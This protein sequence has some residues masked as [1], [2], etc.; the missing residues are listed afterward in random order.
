MR[1]DLILF[2]GNFYTMDE[3]CP[4]AKAVA[5]SGNRFIA[6]GDDEDM[7]GLLRPGGEA[8]NLDGRTVL[9]GF[10]DCHIHFAEYA[11]RMERIDLA[12]VKS[13]E[14]ALELVKERAL[15]SKPGE[16]LLGGGWDRNIWEES[17]FPTKEELDAVS[18]NNPVALHSKDGHVYWVNSS[19][20]NLA[21]IIPS[22]PNPPG[23]EIE[24]DE[25]G[26]PTGILKEK[27][28]ELID[29]VIEEPS[30]ETLQAAMKK[31]IEKAHRVGL[32]GIHD[33]ER[34]HAFIA[35]QELARRGELTLR[36]LMHIPVEE[37]EAAIELGI[38]S[39][40]GNELLR[41]GGVK[42][43]ADGT[44]GSR[45]AAMLAPYEDEP[46]NYG[47]LVTPKEELR[48]IVHK[49]S[50]AGISA[51][52]HAIGDRANRNALDALAELYPSSLRHRIEHAQLLNPLEIPRFARLNVIASVQPIHCTSDM[53]M[54]ERHWGERG[55]WAY[56]FR[57]LLDEGTV[58]AFG[59]DC[60]VEVLDPLIGIHAAVTRR[61]PDGYPGDYGW[62]PEQRISVE[63]AVRAYTLGAAYSSCEESM[64]GS[65]TPG[66]LADLVVLSEDIFAINPMEIMGTEVVATIFDGKF[67]HRI[68]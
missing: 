51:V 1:A 12:G 2:N 22:T 26:N 58:L 57:S 49:A 60:P 46:E 43:F 3:A 16:W 29:K 44:L 33:C 42:I 30:Q 18:W 32:V 65:I 50:K 48:K 54:V 14:E 52:I 31:A 38:R 63:E 21:G 15:A 10:T 47:I 68:I 56:A 66:K 4:R 20:L 28:K 23:G 62:H 45:T 53:E 64:K 61:R 24:R 6:V 41:I 55:K 39:G 19:A 13:L 25:S 36:V 17:S 8:V 67:V 59:S 40:F 7:K 27:A 37:L 9:P 35:F 5:I 34:R 11:L